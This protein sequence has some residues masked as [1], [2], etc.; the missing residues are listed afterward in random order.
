M[1]YDLPLISIRLAGALR[2]RFAAW[3]GSHHC[4]ADLSSDSRRLLLVDLGG[5]SGAFIT[6]CYQVFFLAYGLQFFLGVFVINTASL[7]A[8]VLALWLNH[9][10]RHE[11]ARDLLFV[12]TCVQL[13]LA[14]L[15]TGI[16]VNVFYFPVIVTL[17]LLYDRHQPSIFVRFGLVIVAL[18]LIAQFGRV[19]PVL[20]DSVLRTIHLFNMM[21]AMGLVAVLVHLFNRQIVH[22]ERSLRESNATLEKL[23][24]TDEL[25]GLVNRRGIM[26]AFEREWL[27]ARRNHE[28]LT[29]LMCD[30]DDFKLYND[31]YGHPA[32]DRVLRRIAGVFAQ[33]AQRASDAVARIGGEEFLMVLP[34]VSSGDGVLLAERVRAQVQALGI[35]HADSRVAPVVTTSIGVATLLPDDT[36]SANLLLVRAD[37][38]LYRAKVG[39]RNRVAGDGV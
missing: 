24:T 8:Y 19:Q 2:T 15:L 13:C 27:R 39:G 11:A 38:A 33:A 34:G 26:A 18:F 17:P 30:V 32:G 28:P 21:G 29:V 4:D 20:S 31:L 12:T 37:E 5:V 22:M 9:R 1:G 6:L 16:D 14:D 35:V 3:Y 23:S 7:G 10:D 36:L 25:T